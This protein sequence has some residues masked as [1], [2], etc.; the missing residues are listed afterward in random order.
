M[1]LFVNLQLSRCS[2]LWVLTF[3]WKIG[4]WYQNWELSW[5]LL[6]SDLLFVVKQFETGQPLSINGFCPN[7]NPKSFK[8]KKG[9]KYRIFLVFL[10]ALSNLFTF[11]VK[12]PTFS[13][14]DT[15]YTEIAA[16]QMTKQTQTNFIFLNILYYFCSDK[17]WLFS[18][19]LFLFVYYFFR[20]KSLIWY[21][22]VYLSTTWNFH[23]F[24]S[25]KDE[26]KFITLCCMF[27]YMYLSL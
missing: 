5:N 24:L 10:A 20:V 21:F 3:T 26:K 16:T 17:W 8:S 13:W 14:L 7:P 25:Q 6:S 15:L 19:K 18:F 1:K 9:V 12:F 27:L 4:V 22:S 23:L 2:H 11:S